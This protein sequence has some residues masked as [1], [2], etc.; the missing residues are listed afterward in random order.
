MTLG[1]CQTANKLA[2]EEAASDKRAGWKLTFSDDFDG[3]RGAR[4]DA[5]KWQ[6]ENYNR[7]D[8]PDG[9]DGWWD[10]DNVRLDGEGNL[11][12]SVTQISNRNRD[13]DP[14]DF[15]AGMVST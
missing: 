11:I 15:A 2:S 4:P 14:H 8:N 13:N 6:S 7:R 12:L 10:P 3:A 9:P 5:K 1:S